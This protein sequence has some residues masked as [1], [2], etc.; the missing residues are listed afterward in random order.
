MRKR[1]T[2]LVFVAASW[3]AV[4]GLLLIV[5]ALLVFLAQRAS[6]A[7]GPGMVFGDADWW[8]AIIGRA[9]VFG[10]LWPAIAG[11]ISLVVL[12]SLLSL[13]LGTATG[14]YLSEYAGDR[15]KR[16]LGVLVDVLAGIPSIVM[17]L[18]GFLVILLLRRTIAPDVTTGFI[19]AAGCLAL[20]VLPYTIRVTAGSIDSLDEE[21]RLL[22]PS[23]GMSRTG[24]LV[25]VILPSASKGILSGA[26]LS[27]GRAAEDTAVIMLTGAVATA[28]SSWP[29]GPLAKFEALP[30]RIFVTAAEHNTAEELNAGFAAALVLVGLTAA[31][32]SVAYVFERSLHRRWSQ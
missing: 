28:G 17:G 3:S 11:T 31:L 7:V 29:S 16:V 32:F 6:D 21:V 8:P 18:F 19:V 5:G 2:E 1:A 14:I 10:G 23:L 24:S 4:I 26:I 20:L 15:V 22:G 30:F 12:S 13:P 27:I 9:P 25:A